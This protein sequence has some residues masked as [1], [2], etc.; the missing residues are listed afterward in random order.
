MTIYVPI[1]PIDMLLTDSLFNVHDKNVIPECLLEFTMDLSHTERAGVLVRH[2]RLLQKRVFVA[3]AKI[4]RNTR[5]PKRYL[6]KSAMQ[7]ESA[8]REWHIRGIYDDEV[9][10]AKQQA[11][12]LNRFGNHGQQAAANVKKP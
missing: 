11:H 1:V 9:C 8:E 2:V 10:V 3:G 6:I 5:R 12:R 7:P 4:C